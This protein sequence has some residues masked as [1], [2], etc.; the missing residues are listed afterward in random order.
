MLQVLE[1]MRQRRQRRT[2]GLPPPVLQQKMLPSSSRH[3]PPGSRRQLQSMSYCYPPS[4]SAQRSGAGHPGDDAGDTQATWQV[5][6]CSAYA[7]WMKLVM[8]DLDPSLWR[9]FQMEHLQ[10]LYQYLGLND[11]LKVQQ[12]DPSFVQQPGPSYSQQP[13]IYGQCQ[14]PCSSPSSAMWQPTP[15]HWPPVLQ[16][17]TSL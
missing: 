4:R 16:Q 10:L 17:G 1:G 9:H 2:D 5:M 12:Q 3:A 11:G 8:E 7:D 14:N 15:V 13:P 6:E